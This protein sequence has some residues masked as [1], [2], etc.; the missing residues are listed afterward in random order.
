MKAPRESDT[1]RDILQYLNLLRIPA[2]RN[3]SG[4]L[5]ATYKGRDRMIRMGPKGSSDILGVLP[6]SGR[7]LC[8]EVKRLGNKPT[9]HQTAW[10]EQMRS[11]G[12]VCVVAYGIEDVQRALREAGVIG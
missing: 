3:N 2:W 1:Q 4:M 5:S 9:E 10:L 8:I 6:P 11:A 7:L 12:A